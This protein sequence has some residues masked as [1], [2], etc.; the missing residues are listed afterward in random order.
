[1]LRCRDIVELLDDYL[2]GTLEP[3]DALALE[4]HLRGCQDCTA[5]LAT[6]RGT[7][8]AS[9]D[10]SEDQLPGELRERLLSLLRRPPSA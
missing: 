3:A 2:D 10:L 7:V 6:Y 9:R 1:M 8:R 4:V 5:F